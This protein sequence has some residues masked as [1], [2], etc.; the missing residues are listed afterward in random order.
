MNEQL[1]G[2]SFAEEEKLLL[3]FSGLMSETPLDMILW[4]FAAW[5]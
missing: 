1:N 3:L 5:D 2:R 4:V